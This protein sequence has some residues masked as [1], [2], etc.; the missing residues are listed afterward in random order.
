MPIPIS[1]LHLYFYLYI[2]ISS[3]HVILQLSFDST[4]STNYN[5][6]FAGIC[7]GSM[8]CVPATL[9]WLLTLPRTGYITVSNFWLAVNF[10]PSGPA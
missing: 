5:G 6:R 10:S 4:V 9:P 2:S 8:Y 1:R 3:L 7:Y